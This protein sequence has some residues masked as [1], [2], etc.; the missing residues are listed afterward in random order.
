MNLCLLYKM[1]GIHANFF[2]YVQRNKEWAGIKEK[3]QV[4]ST[5][6]LMLDVITSATAS[7][8]LPSYGSHY[9]G[10]SRLAS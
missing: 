9:S 1:I 6:V 7:L 5:I 2:P 4:L 10:V 8:A 3:K